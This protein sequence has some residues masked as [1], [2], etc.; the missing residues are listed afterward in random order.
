[1]KG[2]LFG[3]WSMTALIGLAPIPAAAAPQ[4]GPSASFKDWTIG[5]D[6]ALTCTAVLLPE[7]SQ[8]DEAERSR[9]LVAITREAGSAGQLAFGFT[10]D[11][12]STGN[13]IRPGH[14]LQLR[15]DGKT[16]ITTRPEAFGLVAGDDQALRG[17]LHSDADIMALVTAMAAGSAFSIGSDG[18]EIANM[19]LAG[20]SATLRFMDDRQHRAGT[21]AALVAKGSKPAAGVPAAPDLP[22]IRR[23]QPPA[24]ELTTAEVD[25]LAARV[26]KAVPEDGGPNE[27]HG[28]N[29]DQDPASFQ[30]GGFAISASL[31]VI[32]LRCGT[33]GAYNHL[34]GFYGVDRVTGEPRP[35]IIEEVGGAHM[36]EDNGHGVTVVTNPGF[37]PKT[38]TLSS[39][40]GGRGVGDCGSWAEFVWDGTHFATS[41]LRKMETCRGVYRD[42]WPFSYRARV[43]PPL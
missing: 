38:L 35:V 13:G 9:S 3:Y 16:V 4:P 2:C 23:A 7:A 42:D 27:C 41:L 43:L 29:A 15:V 12:D 19:S 37:D 34:M 28:M 30:A 8:G 17:A 40:A 6:T 31:A 39:F 26:R 11:G 33:S 21:A 18:A 22:T 25:K 36:I 1:M 10:L 24:A 20:L 5:C 14:T 32:T